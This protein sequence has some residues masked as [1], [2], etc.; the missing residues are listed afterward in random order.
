MRQPS[1]L[2][3]HSNETKVRIV[4]NDVRNDVE[5]SI[6]LVLSSFICPLITELFGYLCRNAILLQF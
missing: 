3:K 6:S 4:R 5:S 1:C 2:N